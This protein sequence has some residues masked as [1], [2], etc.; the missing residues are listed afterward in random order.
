MWD[1]VCG[2]VHSVFAAF[3]WVSVGSYSALRKLASCRLL[4]IGSYTLQCNVL[5]LMSKGL[6]FK[7]K[8][9]REKRQE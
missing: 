6:A 1:H 8:A 3:L 5:R 2:G 7:E 9:Q 4:K